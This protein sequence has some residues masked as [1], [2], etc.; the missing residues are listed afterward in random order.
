MPRPGVLGLQTQ[1]P[2]PP[3]TPHRPAPCTGP[4]PHRPRS[5][6]PASPASPAARRA[7]SGCA[8]ARARRC[9]PQLRPRVARP[10]VRS[11]ALGFASVVR[12]R[13]CRRR[14][15]GACVFC[16]PGAEA[17]VRWRPRCRPLPWS[18]PPPSPHGASLTIPWWCVHP[19][20]GYRR[21][22]TTQNGNTSGSPDSR[23]RNAGNQERLLP[24]LASEPAPKVHG[25]AGI[26]ARLRSRGR[27]GPWCSL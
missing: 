2:P 25:K 26:G 27:L 17:A 8:P 15:S 9:G 18:R 19:E 5:R 13:C 3:D 21:A 12:R 7:L 22:P 23:C 14:C 4:A 20:P 11:H 10:R 24:S 1:S 16:V 6:P